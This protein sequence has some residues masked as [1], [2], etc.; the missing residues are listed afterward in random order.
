MAV[1]CFDSGYV[2]KKRMVWKENFAEHWFNPFPRFNQFLDM[3]KYKA[4]ADDKLKVAEMSIFLFD[5]AENTVGKGEMLVTS[6]F[7][8]C[9]VLQSLLL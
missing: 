4:F 2:G 7:S 6:I 9:S 5:R 3:T 8:F 1:H